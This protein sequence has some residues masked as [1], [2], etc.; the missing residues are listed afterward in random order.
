M[1]VFMSSSEDST[2]TTPLTERELG[3]EFD[4]YG[5]L[6]EELSRR[7]GVDPVPPAG[8][9]DEVPSDT[10]LEARFTYEVHAT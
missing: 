6:V 5:K 3:E 10:I 8:T 7:F 9:D 2:P 1:P 4:R